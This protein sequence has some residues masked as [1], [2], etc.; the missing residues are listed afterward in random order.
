ME[1]MVEGKT[2]PRSVIFKTW[3]Q[4]FGGIAV[5][6]IVQIFWWFEVTYTHE[7]RAFENCTADLQVDPYLGAIIEGIATLL[8]RLSSKTIGELNPKYSTVIDSFIG[9]S[10]V[11]AAFNFSGGYFNPV[12][13]TS[14][15]W[16]CTGHTG[17]QHIIVYWIGA[18]IGALLSVP[19]FR[20]PAIHNL[21]VGIKEK[22]A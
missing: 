11:V 9:T 6:R 14:L 1:D 8:C 3:A 4:L 21:L 5:Y 16:G 15:K 7:G 20:T 12:L 2:S 19:L 18:C 10:L 13:A 17:L 22:E